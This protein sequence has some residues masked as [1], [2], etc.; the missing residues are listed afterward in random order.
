MWSF[1]SVKGGVGKST[2]AVACAKLLAR[3]GR[4]PV[5][6][7]CDMAGTSLAD[8]LRLLAPRVALAD[9][10]AMDLNAPPAGNFLDWETTRRQRAARRDGRRPAPPPYLNDALRADALQV[11]AVL[12]RHERD[13][14]VRYLPSSPL[15]AD[16]A[17]A[18]GWLSA[19]PFDWLQAFTWLL[20]A[21]IAQQPAL[22][23]IVLDLPPGV[24]GFAHEVLVL[25]AALQRGESLPEGYPSW[26]GLTWTAK[27]F[28]V[29]T[30]DRGDLLPALEY[31]AREVHVE[32]HLHDL[33]P[34]VN[35]RTEALGETRKAARELLGPALGPLGVE[36]P[37]RA[38]DILP[39]LGKLFLAQDLVLDESV[40]RL[41]EVLEIPN[42]S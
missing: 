36:E 19:S 15:Q 31:L 7:D 33:I 2:L 22:T 13:D 23:D 27:P 24:W 35:R 30:A 34:I 4:L 16:I 25:T 17:T 42:R 28:L 10:T 11:D 26:T 21:L 3:F 37:L 18:L 5:L 39:A 32:G 14:G 1:C 38:V 9:D 20:E 29:M 41:A 40:Q 8:G 12:W 6:V